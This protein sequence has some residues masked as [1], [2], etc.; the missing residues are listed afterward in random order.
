MTTG[1]DKQRGRVETQQ[2]M[3]SYIHTYITKIPRGQRKHAEKKTKIIDNRN[4]KLSSMMMGW[5]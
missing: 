3:E 4:T 1:Q 2:G 5:S